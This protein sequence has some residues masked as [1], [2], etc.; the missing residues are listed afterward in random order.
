[1]N[2][3]IPPT[4]SG[5][6]ELNTPK[7]YLKA[8]WRRPASNDNGRQP[9]VASSPPRWVDLGPNFRMSWERFMSE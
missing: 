4:Q 6:P 1:M 7:V 8:L 2:F 5:N 9:V 3:L